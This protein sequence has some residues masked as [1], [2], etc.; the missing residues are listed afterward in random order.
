[1]LVQ[2]FYLLLL[3][4]RVIASTSVF[5]TQ[6]KVYRK[7]SWFYKC[8]SLSLLQRTDKQNKCE[9]RT[10][11]ECLYCV[12]EGSTHNVRPRNLVTNNSSANSKS[13]SSKSSCFEENKIAESQ[14]SLR[15]NVSH[16][17]VI[18]YRGNRRRK[19]NAGQCFKQ[20]PVPG[21]EGTM[22]KTYL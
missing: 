10:S 21:T 12:T 16:G 17:Y 18:D 15:T 19:Q 2:S 1:M 7:N 8:E 9:K 6:Y 5:A 4:V 3:S 22:G 20:R 14:L 11:E 13:S